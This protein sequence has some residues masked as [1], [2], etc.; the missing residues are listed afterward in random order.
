MT[1]L[2]C[3]SCGSTLLPSGSPLP[4]GIFLLCVNCKRAYGDLK[5]RV[6]EDD[7]AA[8]EQS[9]VLGWAWM[10]VSWKKLSSGFVKG[11]CLNSSVLCARLA[12]LKP[13]F[14]RRI[15]GV[16]LCLGWPSPRAT[17]TCWLS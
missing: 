17:R 6:A 14:V 5:K 8:E 4:P 9:G 10:F 12:Y 15:E 2:D 1:D 3:S 16:S 13:I 7:E 11:S